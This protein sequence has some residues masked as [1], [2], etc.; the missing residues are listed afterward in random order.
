MT[1]PAP[2]TAPAWVAP[3]LV[4]VAIALAVVA[5]V[6]FTRPASDL[7]SFFPG[8]QTGSSHHHIKHGIGA[9]VLAVIALLGAWFA[10]GRK[11]IE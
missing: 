9:A 11:A 10:T 4:I 3:V 8:H 2:R 1:N 7:P 6:Y 5:V